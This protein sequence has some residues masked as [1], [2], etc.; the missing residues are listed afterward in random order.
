MIMGKADKE[1]IDALLAAIRAEGDGFNYYSMAAGSIKDEKGRQVFSSLAQEELAHKHFLEAQLESYRK[2]G[3]VDKSVQLGQAASLESDNPI[4]SADIK[5][6][7]KE[8]HF[9]MSALSVGIQLEL[10]AQN[11]YRQEAAAA[12]DPDIK[13]F[14]EKLAKWESLHYQALLRQQDALKDD[15]WSAGGFAPF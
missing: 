8:A 3:S 13:E 5:S 15:Y 4:F 10:S 12:S 2:S 6:R 1:I 14:F 11:F 9:E 7:L